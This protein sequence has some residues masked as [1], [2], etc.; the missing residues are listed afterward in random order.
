MFTVFD[1]DRRI[2]HALNPLTTKNYNFL[3]Y[4][5]ASFSWLKTRNFWTKPMFPYNFGCALQESVVKIE[6]GPVGN[7]IW[8][9]IWR[10]VGDSGEFWSTLCL[11]VKTNTKIFFFTFFRMESLEHLKIHSL[12][13]EFA[14]NLKSS[15]ILAC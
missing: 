12:V 15:T 10:K 3:T 1:T 14:W 13:E 7:P 5:Q 8:C 11:G 2:S 4:V 9:R 6:F